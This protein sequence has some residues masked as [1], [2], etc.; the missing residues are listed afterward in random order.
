METVQAE[1]NHFANG[2]AFTTSTFTA[3]IGESTGEALAA[4]TTACSVGASSVVKDS[5][6]D[7]A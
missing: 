3:A 5:L 2:T 4:L 1:V 7:A 6:K